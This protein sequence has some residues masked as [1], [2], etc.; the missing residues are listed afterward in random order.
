MGKSLCAV[1]KHALVSRD[2]PWV[3]GMQ[4]RALT[5]SIRKTTAGSSPGQDEL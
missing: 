2:I 3:E 4:C 5:F 1:C